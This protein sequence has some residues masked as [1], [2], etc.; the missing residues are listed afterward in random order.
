MKYYKYL[1][2][3]N[4][5][6]KYLETINNIKFT[7]RE[8]DIIA[9]V[10]NGRST[11]SISSFLLLSPKTVETHLRN[12]M[13]KLGC[14]ARDGIINFIEKSNK[15][16]LIKEYYISLL[17]QISFEK[18]L[19]EISSNLKSNH[20][21]CFI[22]YWEEDNHI[23]L[24]RQLENHLKLCGIDVHLENRGGDEFS[25]FLLNNVEAE[26][27]Y[28]I[29]YCLS[30]KFLNEDKSKK[31]K[32]FSLVRS[33]FQNISQIIFLIFDENKKE[34]LEIDNNNRYI[35]FNESKYYDSVFSILKHILKDIDINK[36][37]EGFHE[38]CDSIYG[39]SDNEIKKNN[40]SYIQRLNNQIKKLIKAPQAFIGLALLIILSLLIFFMVH[41]HSNM[42]EVIQ[43]K[44]VIQ[45]DFMLPNG[46]TLLNRHKLL[47][48]ISKKFERQNQDIRIIALVGIGGAGKTTLARQFS[49]QQNSQLVWE[50]NANT[51]E[52]LINSFEN[53][54]QNLCKT[55]EEEKALRELQDIKN[56]K[57]KEDKLIVFVR[58]KLKAIKNWILIF[59]NVEKL[60]EIQKYLPHD[61]RFWGQGK[62]LIT[63]VDHNIQ[64]NNFIKDI[65][66]IKELSDEEMLDLFNNIIQNGTSENFNVHKSKQTKKFLKTLPPFPLD[67]SIAAYYLKATNIS[68]KK[69]QEYLNNYDDKF[70]KIQENILKESSEYK[71]TRY[72]IITLSL[73]RLID[74]NK[75]FGD[76]LLLISLL[77]SENIPRILLENY[78][79]DTIV[80]DF[81]YNLKKHSLLT[82]KQPELSALGAN[83]S[84]HRSTQEIIFLYI[85]KTLG[86][87]QNQ[88]L[89]QS[90]FESLI[91]YTNKMIDDENLIKLKCL[92]AH[93]ETILKHKNI[94][95][96]AISGEIE[97]ELGCI[98]FYLGNRKKA[99]E[100]F[101]KSLP[102]LKKYYG[103]NDTRVAWSLGHLG[104][105]YRKL[106]EFEKAQCYL[107]QSLEIYKRYFSE[108]YYTVAWTVARLGNVYREIGDYP[109][110]K[111]YFEDS[112][113]NLKKYYGENH[114]RIAWVLT[115]LGDVYRKLGDLKK[116]TKLFEQSIYIYENH[117]PVNQLRIAW[118]L[119]YL[120]N[121]YGEMGYY[122]KAKKLL[123][124]TL[125]IYKEY[126]SED[127]ERVAWILIHLADMEI[128]L[129]NYE[130]AQ[131]L[132]EKAIEIYKKTFEKD[133]FNIAWA[134]SYLA[135]VYNKL[136]FPEKS[137]P[138][139]E[140]ILEVYEKKYGK[141][142][143]K[144]ARIFKMLGEV[145]MLRGSLDN[146]ENYLKEALNIYQKTKY[147]ESYIPLESLGELYEKKCSQIKNKN[148][149]KN[150]RNQA[151]DYMNQALEVIKLHFPEDSPHITKIKSKLKN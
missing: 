137:Q 106:G 146:A 98:Y 70:T 53:L 78:K 99:K 90:I 6:L 68:Y 87:G 121:I 56:P 79:N 63:T 131:K 29:L 107:E 54:A 69:Y 74:S 130:N 117:F 12:V 124:Q 59:D 148:E 44:E 50:I 36:S 96:E 104:D 55:I 129:N 51:H 139:L 83:F 77:D 82:E 22:I 24:V 34:Y 15:Y 105:V 4:I 14:N 38:K 57:E 134:S 149:A 132:I 64:N 35:E 17:V 141:D 91:N 32:F 39:F 45:S 125:V 47:E 27:N 5:F 65:I 100:L 8:I 133:H 3:Q 58:G 94:L 143:I 60:I 93:Y 62:V 75:N 118:V 71:K 136:G 30:E 33:A 95:T 73:K 88:Y 140:E 21:K 86:L 113:P 31:S 128:H 7:R 144:I 126:F 114:P 123:E 102:K 80:D 40:S 110:A 138:L 150:F 25:I 41:P 46:F 135:C 48:E 72:G 13:L 19:Q 142:H 67:V 2:P 11:K 81:I 145:H 122:E 109:K 10:L 103:E 1:L 89:I 9:Y 23:Q 18:F 61:A 84:I 85:V 116:A 127:Y 147:Y 101:E 151:L 92:T 52:T 111:K 119:G 76:L 97:S 112:L 37:I 66:H 42:K 26:K 108:N 115:N 16:S 20:N 43:N 49:R 120:S 28:N